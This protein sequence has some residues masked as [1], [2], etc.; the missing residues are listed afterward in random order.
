[1]R[2]TAVDGESL[3][4]PHPSRSVPHPSLPV[5]R[6]T[7]VAVAVLLA[8]VLITGGAAA[9]FAV[10]AGP[11][12]AALAAVDSDPDITVERGDD[13]TVVRSGPITEETVGLVYYPGARVNP[14]SYAPTA[15]AIVADRDVAVVVVEMPL[16]LAV[17]APNRADDA[18]AAAPEIESWAVGGHSLG[19]AMA[20]RYAAENADK[21]DALVLHA[22]YCDRD[23]SE[24]DLRVLTV[25]GAAD[26]V[27]D[28]DR[29]RESRANL[30]ADTR[31]VELDGVNH[32]GFGAYGPQRGDTSVSTDPAVMQDR[33]GNATGHWL[34]A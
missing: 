25:L 33:V 27:I 7:I 19:G 1:M 4:V 31:V 18:R 8:V 14:E 16:N 11:D 10:G 22:S 21:V 3:S 34:T 2:S 9:Y 13:W 23:I 6:W 29:E 32:A 26:G 30:P 5:H 12:A 28:S 20:C 24:T 15:A 17:L